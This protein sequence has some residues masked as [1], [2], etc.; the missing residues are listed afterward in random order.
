MSYVV[1][2]TKKVFSKSAQ[3]EIETKRYYTFR[4]RGVAYSTKNMFEKNAST[5]SV[6]IYKEVEEDG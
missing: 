2:L 3:R 4:D 5:V 6:K 1:V